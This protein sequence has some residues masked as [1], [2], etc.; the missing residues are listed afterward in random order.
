MFN[1][2]VNDIPPFQ[3][4]RNNEVNLVDIILDFY[5]QYPLEE[6][7]SR[8]WSWYIDAVQ[9]PEVNAGD[10]VLFFES[11]KQLLEAVYTFSKEVFSND[12]KL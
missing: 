6:V 11:L 4:V 12:H 2:S 3:L 1:D 10:L 9:N 5:W 8:I 7:Q